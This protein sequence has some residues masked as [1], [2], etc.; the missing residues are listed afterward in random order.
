MLLNKPESI[1]DFKVGQVYKIN[2]ASRS[3][4]TQ[5]YYVEILEVNNSFIDKINSSYYIV[6]GIPSGHTLKITPDNNWD[7]HIPRMTYM[8]TKEQCKYLI[9]NQNVIDF[10]NK[11][12]LYEDF[13]PNQQ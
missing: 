10:K 5:P 8:G 3:H 6:T 1:S 7:Y 13:K 11:P 2:V 9:N 12:D 4:V